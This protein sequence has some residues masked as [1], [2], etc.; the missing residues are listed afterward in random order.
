MLFLSAALLLPSRNEDETG[1]MRLYFEK[2]GRYAL[3][4]YAA[5][6]LLGAVAN[7]VFFEAPPLA[8]WALLDVAMIV[9]PI[10]TFAVK[11][12]SVYAALTLAYLPLAA[13]DTWLSLTS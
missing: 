2:D 6:L 10:V 8:A 3:L 5:F 4:A 7:V 1:G 9:L 11:S 13:L 12:R